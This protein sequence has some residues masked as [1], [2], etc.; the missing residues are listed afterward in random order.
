MY[1]LH[2]IYMYLLHHSALAVSTITTNPVTIYCYTTT[3]MTTMA[4][5]FTTTY[6]IVQVYTTTNV[7]DILYLLIILWVVYSDLRPKCVITTI[8]IA[9]Q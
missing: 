4:T 1:T 7:H 2:T 3:R 5:T 9:G 8:L 6:T